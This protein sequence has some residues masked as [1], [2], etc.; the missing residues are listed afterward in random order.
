M[1]G[2]HLAFEIGQRLVIAE[3]VELRHDALEHAEGM[4]NAALEACQRIARD[5]LVERVLGFAAVLWAGFAAGGRSLGFRHFLLLVD[6]EEECRR[7]AAGVRVRRPLQCQ[8]M[9]GLELRAGLLELRRAFRI[10]ETRQVV[11]EGAVRIVSDLPPVG[12]DVEPPSHGRDDETHCWRA[13]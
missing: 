5:A 10:D 13:P 6:F 7:L 9:D 4:A 2:R 12:L 8:V 3:P 1:R 11:V